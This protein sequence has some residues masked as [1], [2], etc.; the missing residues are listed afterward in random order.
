[1][2]LKK[3]TLKKYWS[4]PVWSKV[5]SA[6]IL[7]V[8]GFLLTSVYIIIKSIFNQ[9]PFRTVYDQVLIY[10][11][12]GTKINNF[13][14][15]IFTLILLWNLFAFFQL[16]ISKFKQKVEIEYIPEPLP[17]L[18]QTSTS[19][20]SSRLAN[21]FPGQRGLKW[22]DGKTAVARLKI[23]LKQPL[24]FDP[25]EGSSAVSDPFWWLRA[26]QSSE[27]KNFEILTKTKVLLGYDELE[28]KRIAVNI[29][30]NY[31]KSYIYV[32]VS[33]EKPTGLYDWSPEKIEDHIETFGYCSEEY[34]LLGKVPITREHYDD[35]ATI[36]KNKVID[37][38][39]AKLRVRYL[40]EYNFII[41]A[42]Q[43]PFNS[44]K[45]D[46]D[47]D[48]FLDEILQGKKT[49]EDFFDIIDK[50]KR[51]DYE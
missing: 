8:G 39:G 21:A 26:G 38:Y 31:Y 22:Y 51:N 45:F 30:R 33:A 37:S 24:E 28:I 6:I 12:E 2:N 16:L 11:S 17:K 35:G 9:I 36:I 15:W 41:V 20:F 1:M 19:L 4:D 42:K 14:I 3:E 13:I 18:G 10:F 32:E 48:P 23:A 5:I 46:K 47:S 34:A 27:I 50:Y 25:I 40:S 29:S 44:N 49:P 7:T 43:S